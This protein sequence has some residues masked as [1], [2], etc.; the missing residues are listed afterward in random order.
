[1]KFQTALC[2]PAPDGLQYCSRLRFAPAMDDYIVSET[3]E[4]DGRKRPRHPHVERIMQEQV[5]QERTDDTAL[6]GAFRPFHQDP[7][8]TLDRGTQ[9][10]AH[11]QPYPGEFSVVRHGAFDEVMRNGIK[12]C[13]D[14]LY[15]VRAFRTV[16]LAI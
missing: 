7:V 10:P 12:E 1:M 13:F 11:V 2:Q 5:G 9:P 6:R 16:G 3:L 15:V 14:V 4:V 8:R